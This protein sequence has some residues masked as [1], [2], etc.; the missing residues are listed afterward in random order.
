VNPQ[1]I[2]YQRLEAAC[3]RVLQATP[4]ARAAALN[5]ACGDDEALRTEVEA[6]VALE[7]RAGSFLDESV[8]EKL[9]TSDP[10]IGRTVGRWTL[11]ALL[12]AGGMGAVYLA[13]RSDGVVEQQAAV[14][15]LAAH[16]VKP[17]HRRRFERERQILASLDHPC[18]ARLVDGG[19]TPEGQPY[20]VME[21]VDGAPL[22]EHCDAA[23]LS[24]GERLGLFERV[25]SAVDHAHHHLVIHRDLKPGNILV[26]STGAP[27]LVDFGIATVLHE[28]DH[29]DRTQ[30]AER[31]FTP[32]YAS[33]EQLDG[34]HVTTATDVYSLGIVLY[35]LVAGRRPY[36]IG[37][38]TTSVE[39][40]RLVEGLT[41]PSRLLETQDADNATTIARA[42]GTDPGR[43]R[44]RIRGDLDTV[45]LTA[46]RAE[47]DDRYASADR[48]R[49]DVERTRTGLPILA[50]PASLGY[51]ARKFVAR[52][53]A[54]VAAAV[55]AVVVIVAASAASVVMYFQARTASELA[56]RQ[57]RTAETINTYLTDML[58][59]V[60]PA[61]AQGRDVSVFHE[62]LDRTAAR[63]R[64]ELGDAPLIAAELHHTVGT[65]YAAISAYAAAADHL[66]AAADLRAAAGAPLVDRVASLIALGQTWGEANHF[67]D[68]HAALEEACELVAAA[69]PV[70]E[71]LHGHALACL[72]DLER[73]RGAFEDAEVHLHEGLSL[74]R[75][76]EASPPRLAFALEKLGYLMVHRTRMDEGRPLLEEAAELLRAEYGDMHPRIATVEQELGWC[77][78]RSGDLDTALAHYV[79]SLAIREAIL[80]PDH[81]HLANSLIG[82]GA[83]LED[84]RRYE[85]AERHYLR[86]RDV[87]LASVGRQHTEMGTLCNNLGGLYRKLER[88]DEALDMLEEAAAIYVSVRG[89]DDFW[90]SFPHMHLALVHLG[91]NRPQA[92]LDAADECLR[93]R[94]ANIPESHSEIQ[95]IRT[96]RGMALLGL[97]RAAEA[98]PVLLA[99]TAAVEAEVDDEH[100]AMLRAMQAM[101]A[102]YEATDR[103]TEAASWRARL[104]A[105][106]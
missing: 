11:R 15:L 85:E 66:R 52:H 73:L 60:D 101:V 3:Q 59:S 58:A 21:H 57:A 49:E 6:F 38:H 46:L 64:D 86:A 25:C 78:R 30:T 102:L 4:E 47:P 43:L 39:F 17:A 44:Q 50:R 10:H 70:D 41:P 90:V 92:A 89:P 12:G 105:D 55:V 14:K 34:R 82:V 22:L 106:D 33:P 56:A 77:A 51:R 9:N 24:I 69:D 40:A 79:E 36:D 76:A 35:E 31:R 54:S 80:D 61:V 8:P 2:H 37:D 94:R 67:D 100:P 1:S 83:V 97:G 32:A 81:Y 88:P 72:G 99:S 103:N 96:L 7:A 74:L 19:I 63:V 75:R 104:K 42:R 20:L 84:L 27:R 29:V 45:V 53:R 98:E 68:G 16:L 93:I 28:N 65:A 13:D 71:G 87:L 18:I 26:D 23:R 48:L 62:A 91:E 95:Q 5:E